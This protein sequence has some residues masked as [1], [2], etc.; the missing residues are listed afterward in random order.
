VSGR[1]GTVLGAI[2]V[3]ALLLRL[4]GL[5]GPLWYDE[6]VTLETHL[7][8]PWGAMV[9]DYSMNHHYLF[10]FAA[11]A[12]MAL[13]GEAPWALR[14]PALLLGLAGIGAGWALARQVTGRVAVAHAVALMLAL[15]YHHIWFSQNARGYTGLMLWSTLG[16]GLFL[17]GLRGGSGRV[18]LLYAL[19]LAA[20]IW[21]HLT[22]VFVFMGHGFVW[23]GWLALRAG[24]GEAGRADLL[25]PA[26][27]FAGGLLLAALLLAPLLP[28][29]LA[30][31]GGVAETSAADPMQ[32]YQSPVWA[33]LEGLRVMAGDSPAAL[34][35]GGLALLLLL[36]GAFALSG[37]E[38][39]LGPA[40]LAFILVTIGVLTLLGMRIWPRFFLAGLAPV[41]ILLVEGVRSTCRLPA[42][43]PPLAR[44][45]PPPRAFALA[46]LA[47][48]AVSAVLAA[49][50]YAGPKQDL[51]GAR[52]AVLAR[53]APGDVVAVM[54]VVEKAY[55]LHFRDGWRVI[56]GQAALEAARAEA[57]RAGGR[58][59][60]VIGFPDRTERDFAGLMPE[61]ARDFALEIRLPGTLGDGT[62]Q[63]WASR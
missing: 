28:G 38:P 15:S 56:D 7:R 37:R 16:T 60:I 43:I 24:R 27:A 53:A 17:A 58:V 32:E 35:A 19:T 26:L 14:L 1:D 49:R 5:D 46:I 63:V 59:W 52:T 6:V 30:A 33:M 36:L 45:L 41:M 61:I 51:A 57:M 21:T 48:A 23:L 62:M 8:L 22:G 13:F 44:L 29:I 47:M 2:L 3:L 25:R 20:A 11:K 40:V 39:L 9:S 18:W 54:G 34:A 55:R 12:S 10:S 31:A 42:L 50:N 4:P